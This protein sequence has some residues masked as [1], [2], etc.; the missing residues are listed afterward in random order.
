MPDVTIAY[1]NSTIASISE[2]Q[3]FVGRPVIDHHLHAWITG[4][5]LVSIFCGRIIVQD[6]LDIGF[7]VL[8]NPRE[9]CHEP[10]CDVP[11]AERLHERTYGWKT[12]VILAES[13]FAECAYEF[14]DS[15]LRRKGAGFH[16]GY[17]SNA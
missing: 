15:G 10:V 9:S 5:Y 8:D 17:S 7:Q 2:F 13:I 1:K 11:V 3:E 14:E 12:R 4:H 6:C 16:T